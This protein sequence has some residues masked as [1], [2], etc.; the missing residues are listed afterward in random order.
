MSAIRPDLPLP[1]PGVQSA[2]DARA[3]QAA[4]FRAAMG[5]PGP[6]APVETKRA[7]LDPSTLPRPLADRVEAM[8]EGRLLRP[9]SM[10][11]IR[12]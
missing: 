11:D 2:N 9:G 4:F 1:L 8:Q 5:Q 6:A 10:L 7:P 3:A 12:I